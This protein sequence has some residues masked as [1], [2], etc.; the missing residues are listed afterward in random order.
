MKF[1]HEYTSKTNMEEKN[2]I[3]KVFIFV[4]FAHKIFS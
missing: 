2:L 1:S 4:F 3:N